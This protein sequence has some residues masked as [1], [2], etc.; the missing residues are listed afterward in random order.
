MALAKNNAKVNSIYE[1]YIPAGWT[2]CGMDASDEDRELWIQA[3]YIYKMF[4][5][6]TK[7]QG[8]NSFNKNKNPTGVLP[9]RMAD[10]FLV[11]GPGF[12][13]QHGTDVRNSNVNSISFDTKILS[14]YPDSES[15]KDMLLPENIGPFVF[16]SGVHLTQQENKPFF[17]TF[18][19]TD[20][21]GIKMYG[22]TLHVNELVEPPELAAMIGHP[23]TS[24]RFPRWPIVWKPKALT[25]L[26]HYPFYNLFREFLEQLYRISLSASPIPIE[27]YV[28]N[29]MNELP[30]P[31]QGRYE[32]NFTLPDR[33]I[34]IRR[35]R[36]NQLPM[37]DFSYRPLFTFL[38][39]DN[40]L[41]VFSALCV[42]KNVCFYSTNIALLTPVQ[43]A[44]LSLLFPLVWQGAYVP[45]LPNDMLDILDAPVPIMVGI[46]KDVIHSSTEMNKHPHI[47]FIDLDNDQINFGVD[48]RGKALPPPILLHSPRARDK[49]KA[50]L[51]EFANIFGQNRY[52]PAGLSFPQSE[53]LV[54]IKGFAGEIGITQ[55][56]NT[57][58]TLSA[59]K[60]KR[61]STGPD[62]DSSVDN[63]REIHPV[64]CSKCSRPSN[65]ILDPANNIDK[66]FNAME[67][68]GAFLRFFAK[69]LKGYDKNIK[70][71]ER[72]G[73]FDRDDTKS[74]TSTPSMASST[75]SSLIKDHHILKD[76]RTQNE[77]L[78]LSR[79][80]V[81]C[82]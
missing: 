65:S 68:R 26:S 73:T 67:I 77:T 78:F 47:I 80:Y 21:S 6:P 44:F 19:L 32:V 17:F 64:L 45:I 2:K 50:K 11:I 75:M 54:P 15:Y 12:C 18:V 42:E 72:F 43:E 10:F 4:A 7:K 24:E 82:K 53:H 39:I 56:I 30:L 31:P 40:I 38:S 27:R 3:K 13:R 71:M 81:T 14:C 62:D 79:M 29:F 1:R 66:D 60:N 51:L 61:I 34:N 55:Q 49:L 8:K 25:V 5:L 46:Q 37:V 76:H 74:V 9:I 41:M 28:L 63:D 59:T 35:P 33:T 70:S 36:T 48:D 20:V 69:I 23:V 58:S 57:H 16:P 52:P 22:A